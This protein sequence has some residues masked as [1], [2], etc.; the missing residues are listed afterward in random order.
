MADCNAAF[1]H[2]PT[3]DAD[4]VPFFVDASAPEF[5]GVVG[6]PGGEEE[7]GHSEI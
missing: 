7:G 2:S 1:R 4:D 6:L 3:V 5:L